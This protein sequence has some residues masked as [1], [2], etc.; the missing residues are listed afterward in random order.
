MFVTGSLSVRFHKPTP[1]DKPVTLRA[2]VEE[3]DEKRIRVSC[4][5]YSGET[6]T[7]S[8]ET[9]CFRVDLAGFLGK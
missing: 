6:I 3:M 2:R 7:A 5:L 1:L 4:N 9:E 8:G